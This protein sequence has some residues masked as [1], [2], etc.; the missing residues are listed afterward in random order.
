MDERDERDERDDERDARVVP[1]SLFRADDGRAVSRSVRRVRVRLGARDDDDARARGERE[2][3]RERRLA[4]GVAR[5]DGGVESADGF[6]RR[7]TRG[8]ETKVSLGDV[9]DEI[10]R[11]RRVG[12][13]SSDDARRRQGR[14]QRTE[15]YEK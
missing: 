15:V 9:R 5:E 1:V 3:E 6:R 2:R 14:A 13:A 12:D 7:R 11:R 10:R 8:R 4:R